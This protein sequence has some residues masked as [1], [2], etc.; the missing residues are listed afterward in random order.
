M[1]KG[2]NG[3]RKFHLRDLVEEHIRCL[4]AKIAAM[5]KWTPDKILLTAQRANSWD[6]LKELEDDDDFYKHRRW[7]K[8]LTPRD[9]W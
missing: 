6:L 2:R 4:D 3:P 8:R 7:K 9:P 1:P 5:P